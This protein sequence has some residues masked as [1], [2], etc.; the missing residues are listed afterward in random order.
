MNFILWQNVFESVN[1][2]WRG[3]VWFSYCT[4]EQC[5]LLGACNME[6]PAHNLHLIHASVH[7]MK[8]PLPDGTGWV[9]SFQKPASDALHFLKSPH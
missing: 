7:Q 2:A 8:S 5:V 1:P 6:L 9:F 4:P 3:C